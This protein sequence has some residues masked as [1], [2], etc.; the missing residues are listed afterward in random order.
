MKMSNLK[1]GQPSNKVKNK[2][3]IEA[4][5][6]SIK[7]IIMKEKSMISQEQKKTGE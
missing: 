3:S 1:R 6:L 4:Q 5:K 7:G 2:N